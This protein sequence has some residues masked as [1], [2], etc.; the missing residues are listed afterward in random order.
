M[1]IDSDDPAVAEAL[2]GLKRTLLANGGGLAGGARAVVQDGAFSIRAEAPRDTCERLIQVPE[3]CLPPVPSFTLDLDGDALVL[4]DAPA[5]LPQA[6]RDCFRQ[7]L[8]LYNAAGKLAAWRAACPWTALAADPDLRTAL[9]DLRAGA[10][11]VEQQ[12]RIADAGEWTAMAVRSF[13]GARTFNLKPRAETAAEQGIAAARGVSA[14]DEVPVIPPFIELLNHDFR[15]RTF[16]LTI[17]PDDI[18]RLWTHIDRPVPGSSECRVRY[19]PMDA[20]DAYLGY[21]FLDDS[22]PFLRSVP[23]TVTLADGS[24]LEAG[25]T[26]GAPFQG[27]LPPQIAEDRFYVPP[28]T[29]SLYAGHLAVARLTIPGPDAAPVLRRVLAFLVTAMQPAAE[30][31]YIRAAVLD[32]EAQVLETNRRRIA[33][34]ERLVADAGTSPPEAEPPGRAAAL[35]AVARLARQM[36]GHLDA[37][38]AAV[39]AQ[40]P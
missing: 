29:D 28:I 1:Q 13:L 34:L 5:D 20:V 21:A 37:Y 6:T 30:S 22:A 7:L 10:P 26:G 24:V 33:A 19:A 11:K 25:A 27:Q 2:N 14:G 31:G 35:D 3:A 16:E 32:A 18:R 40:A 23:V 9:A 8:E 4:V 17:D 36:R 39:G 12:R 38:A 15:A